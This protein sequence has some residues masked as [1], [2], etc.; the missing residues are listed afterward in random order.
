MGSQ[1]HNTNANRRRTHF[2][3]VMW[4][5]I[6]NNTR[7]LVDDLAI[8]NDN[9]WAAICRRERAQHTSRTHVFKRSPILATSGVPI[10]HHR[11][12]KAQL[13]TNNVDGVSRDG[14]AIPPSSHL[15]QPSAAGPMYQKTVPIRWGTASSSSAP[16]TGPGRQLA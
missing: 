5:V 8:I 9:L 7:A 2:E 12:L 6:H 13:D 4:V 16:L 10:E 14:D 11:S 15:M 3:V 1:M